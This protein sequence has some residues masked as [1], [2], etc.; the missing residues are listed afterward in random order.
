M[1]RQEF[2]HGRSSRA[3]SRLKFRPPGFFRTE[4]SRAEKIPARNFKNRK[5]FRLKVEKSKKIWRESWKK[6]Y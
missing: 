5:I 6:G 3:R 2:P 4:S 1:I